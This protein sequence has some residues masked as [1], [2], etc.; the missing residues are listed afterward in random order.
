MKETNPKYWLACS[1][2]VDS[3]VLVHLFKLSKQSFGI[4]HV[5]FKLRGEAS[6]GDE[7]FVRNLA[8]QL[9]VPCR[10]K[11]ADVNKQK[12]NQKGNTQLLARDLRYAW[13]EEV[14]AE[15]GGK[16]VLAHHLDDQV[17]TFF[18]QL[19]RGGGVYGLAGMPKERDGYVRPL[20]TY[21][22]KDLVALAQKN[23]WLWR[24]DVSNQSNA[25]KRNLYRNEL[26][27]VLKEQI[28]AL[29]SRVGEIVLGYQSLLHYLEQLTLEK[30]FSEGNY[31]T[32]TTWNSLPV[33]LQ[34]E[35]LHRYTIPTH[36]YAPIQK[37][38]EGIKGTHIAVGDYTIWNEGDS[39]AF[40]KN[41]P[42][43]PVEMKSQVVEMHDFSLEVDFSK[44]NQFYIDA[45]KVDGAITIRTWRK[46]D[47][48][49]PIGMKGSKLVSDF[50]TDKKVPAH[51]RNG[52]QIIEDQSKIIAIVGSCPS[53]KVKIN[54]ETKK[55]IKII[56]L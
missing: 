33:L 29:D 47:R 1:G 40:V 49:R 13:F 34:K 21:N 35:L 6:D 28:K 19:E 23:D 14:K 54:K 31:L 38:Q 27:P 11:I 16:I 22:K 17:E 24:E 41:V 26:L 7:N 15:T 30:L 46:G 43:K 2:G 51:Q 4:L 44:P 20:L 10:V 42:K 5:N 52:I 12:E 39:Y 45:D 50:L 48:F 32:F 36:Y 55:I 3:V 56:I 8:A 53:E 18:L 25:Y 37:L 9:G